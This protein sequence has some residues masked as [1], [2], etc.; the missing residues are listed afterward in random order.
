[1]IH[2]NHSIIMGMPYSQNAQYLHEAALLFTGH[3]NEMQQNSWLG[4]DDT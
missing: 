2:N 4:K 1:M 3:F